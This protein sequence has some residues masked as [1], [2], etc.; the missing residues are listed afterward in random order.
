MPSPPQT[1]NE[2]TLARV[3]RI[4]TRV[5]Q[6]LVAMGVDTRA[7]KPELDQ[8]TSTMRLQSLHTSMKEIVDNIPANWHADVTVVFGGEIVLIVRRTP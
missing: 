6:L 5:T 3:R 1:T 8:G 4:E 2:E 7:R